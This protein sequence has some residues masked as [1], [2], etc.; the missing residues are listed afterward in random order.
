TD[1]V[2]YVIESFPEIDP[3]LIRKW[4]HAFV[5]F[6]DVNHNGVLEWGD[7]RLLTEIIKAMRGENSDEYKSANIALKEIWDRLLEETH[8]NK[9][10][11]V[12]LVNWIA[13]WQRTLTGEDPYWQKNY[14]EYMFQLFD[15]SG[16]QLIDLA[17]YIEVLSYFNIGRMEAVNC[18]DKFAKMPDGSQK[19]AIDYTKFCSLWDEYFHS[20]DLNAAGYQID[21]RMAHLT[22]KENH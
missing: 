4:H 15:A 17:E 7:Y 11:N 18:F 12:S 3:F 19:M 8:P 16:D 5:T 6:F 2:E 13:M 20:K 9:D 21:L 1:M 14:L 22:V 10:G